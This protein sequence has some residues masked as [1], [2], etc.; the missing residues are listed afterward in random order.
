MI[1]SISIFTL[2]A[3]H[4]LELIAYLFVAY[5]AIWIASYPLRLFIKTIIRFMRVGY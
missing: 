3:V 5:L 1:T 4:T 2:I